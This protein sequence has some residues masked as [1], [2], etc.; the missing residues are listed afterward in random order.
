[1]AG[2]NDPEQPDSWFDGCIGGSPGVAYSPCG[3]DIII[4]EINYHSSDAADAGDWFEIKNQLNTSVDLSGWTVRDI[5]DTH[6]FTFPEGTILASGKFMV[7]CENEDAFNAF[8]PGVPTLIVGLGFG[9]SNSSDVIRLYNATGQLQLSI[10]YDDSD[11][12]S[13]DADGAGYTL[14]LLDVNANMNDG[15]NWFAGCPGGSPGGPYD[16]DCIPVGVNPIA[17]SVELSIFP[18]PFDQNFSVRIME[19][20]TGTMRIIDAFARVILQLPISGQVTTIE[21]GTWS[22]GMYY[23]LTEVN[24]VSV[25]EKVIKL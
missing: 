3:D 22:A 21:T 12:W 4:S 8:H 16:P 9:L 11:P 19:G 1:V 23:I 18:N 25:I 17:S 10:C 13:A 20:T 7:V 24:G 2:I 14:E 6:I 15:S 5:D